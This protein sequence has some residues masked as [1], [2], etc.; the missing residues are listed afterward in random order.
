[1]GKGYV[2]HG[3][4]RC[5]SSFAAG[6]I[7]HRYHGSRESGAPL[8]LHYGDLADSSVIAKLI[9]TNHPDE[10]YNLGALS[11]V[12]VS[13]ELPEYTADAVA[14]GV[15][16]LLEAIRH[17]GVPVRFYPAG[18]SEMFGLAQETPQRETTPFYPRSPT[19][20]PRSSVAP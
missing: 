12:A 6:R 15:L 13:F 2:V 8:R 19:P 18:S 20:R 14:M 17:T 4:V 11:H 5:S 1:L 10:V 9:N 16:R 3:N 7:E